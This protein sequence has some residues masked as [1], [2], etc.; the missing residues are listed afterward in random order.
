VHGTSA[1]CNTAL[2]KEIAKLRSI[3]SLRD[4]SEAEPAIAEPMAP[5][6]RLRLASR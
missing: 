4:E 6:I 5:S 3:V 1:D 2:E